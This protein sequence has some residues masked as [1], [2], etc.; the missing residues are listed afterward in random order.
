M[1]SNHPP[2]GDIFHININKLMWLK[3]LYVCTLIKV[4]EVTLYLLWLS[5]NVYLCIIQLCISDSALVIKIN[6]M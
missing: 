4:K 2:K 6:M 3:L 5:N 1:T